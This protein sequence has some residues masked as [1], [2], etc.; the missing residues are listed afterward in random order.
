MIIASILIFLFG[1]HSYSVHAYS[2]HTSSLHYAY[3]QN[4]V[5]V[6]E[7]FSIHIY[8]LQ[9]EYMQYTVYVHTV[10]MHTV[11]S[12]QTC[13]IQYAYMHTYF[14]TEKSYRKMLF[15]CLYW[16]RNYKY[17]DSHCVV[18]L[19]LNNANICSCTVQNSN[20]L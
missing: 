12:M 2:I 15:Y 20:P 18:L 6:H 13:R 1:M 9:Y 8:T 3:I 10:Y 14:E 16:S 17:N 19:K 4:T 5:Y 11:Y 7:V